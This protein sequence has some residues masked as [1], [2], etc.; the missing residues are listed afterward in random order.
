MA[1]R[2][3]LNDSIDRLNEHLARLQAS[4]ARLRAQLSTRPPH[5]LYALAAK[6]DDQAQ[7]SGSALGHRQARR[8]EHLADAIV[9]PGG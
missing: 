7:R 3:R 6:L 5:E 9:A 4:N 1:D 2:D 8:W